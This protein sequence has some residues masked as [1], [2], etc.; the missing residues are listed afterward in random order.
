MYEF[1][2]KKNPDTPVKN[3]WKWDVK[4]MYADHKTLH[5]D[6][7]LSYA[8]LYMRVYRWG[9]DPVKAVRTPNLWMWG[10]RH[11]SKIYD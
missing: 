10:S 4:K 7:A 9:R 11:R 1:K 8:M 5:W 2:Y 6:K 3:A